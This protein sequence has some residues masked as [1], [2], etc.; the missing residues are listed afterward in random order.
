M[1]GVLQWWSALRLLQRPRVS[2]ITARCTVSCSI[3]HAMRC[4]R[5]ASVGEGV[6]NSLGLNGM[7]TSSGRVFGQKRV[8]PVHSSSSS[9]VRS[10]GIQQKIDMAGRGSE[11]LAVEERDECR[12]ARIVVVK[13]AAP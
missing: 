2:T 1:K 13:V 3:T 6:S 10:F 7:T 12:K 4:E 11:I 5:I 8:V 9:V